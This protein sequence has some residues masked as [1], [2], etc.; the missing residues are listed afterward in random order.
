MIK[1]LIS[2]LKFFFNQKKYQR[3]FFFENSF[4]ENHLAPYLDKSISKNKTLILSKYYQNE[5]FLDDFNKIIIRNN[6]LLN[7]IFSFLQIKY[8]YS[9]TPELGKSYFVKSPFKKTKYI[10]MQHSAMGLN[11]IY[12]DKAFDN[13][14]LVQTV[15]KFQY[16]DL[17]DIN[18]I[19]KKNIK[20]WKSKYIFFNRTFIND[21]I[22]GDKLKVLI[23][24]THGTDFYEKALN[25]LIHCLDD[26]LYEVELRP[27]LVSTKANNNLNSSIQ[28]RIKINYGN[29]DFNSIDV[30]ISDWSGIYLEYAYKKKQ[31]PILINTKQK[32]LNKNFSNF[33]NNSIDIISRQQIAETLNINEIGKIN[34]YIQKI[35]KD[36]NK[37]KNV[38]ENFF[39]NNFY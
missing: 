32:I 35:K 6:F 8:C 1:D 17:L 28:N 23:A 15:N 12:N 9:T 38:I 24:P 7:I 4:T 16:N 22:K 25:D 33:Q 34:N 39:K 5:C 29:L 10:F 21:Q 11:A 30:L 31:K 26:N 2:V 13:F 36:T 37:N 18:R 14:D 20:P 27:H 3:I 19:N